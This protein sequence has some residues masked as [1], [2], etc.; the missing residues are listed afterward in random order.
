MEAVNASAAIVPG[1][2][3]AL[4]LA[5]G[6]AEHTALGNVGDVEGSGPGRDDRLGIGAHAGK[7]DIFWRGA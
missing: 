7:H 5:F 2:D 1:F 3:E 4:R 6:E